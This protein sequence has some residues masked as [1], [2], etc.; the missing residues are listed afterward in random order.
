MQQVS[1]YLNGERDYTR[2]K[3]STGPLV[4]PAAHVYI[5]STLFAWTQDGRDILSGQVIFAA[6]YLTTLAVVISCYRKCRA[7]PY[8]FPLL[9]LSKRLHSIYMLRLFND[10]IAALA[11]WGCVW[12]FQ[13]K[14]WTSAVAVWSFGVG[15]KMTL[16]LLAPAIAMITVLALSLSTSLALGLIAV[17]IQVCILFFILTVL[18]SC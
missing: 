2:L 16:L 14:A 7:P 12:L 15:V 13:R 6:L 5:Y 11:M 1:L 3:G 4:Y 10:G 9:V 17:L 8:L 18:N